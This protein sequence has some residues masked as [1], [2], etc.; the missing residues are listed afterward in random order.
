MTPASQR[1]R[2]RLWYG[3]HSELAHNLAL[4][5]PPS[6]S[7]ELA[8]QAVEAGAVQLLT[9]LVRC[10]SAFTQ[11]RALNTAHGIAAVLTGDGSGQTRAVEAL[12]PVLLL[13][14]Q[15]LQDSSSSFEVAAVCDLLFGAVRLEPADVHA[16]PGDAAGR[17]GWQQRCWAVHARCGQG[18][19][20]APWPDDL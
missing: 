1:R 7:S 3:R 12:R 13:A 10:G 14:V 16:C 8:E 4:L 9:E 17:R 20:P 2:D 11:Q 18:V 6:S 19:H 15:R 5:L